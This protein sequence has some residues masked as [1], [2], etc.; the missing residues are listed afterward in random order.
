[1]CL[2]FTQ[3][4]KNTDMSLKTVFPPIRVKS[5]MWLSRFMKYEF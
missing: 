1:M 2:F 3:I 4:G 5:W